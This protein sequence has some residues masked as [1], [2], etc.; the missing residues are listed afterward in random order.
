MAHGD[1]VGGA[2]GGL[3]AGDAGDLEGIAFGIVRQRREGFGGEGDEGGGFGFAAGR[4]FAADV[5]HA[6][7]ARVVKMR[8]L[9]HGEQ[10][11]AFAGAGREGAAGCGT[12]VGWV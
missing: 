6:R 10:S 9:A 11:I 7:V 3:D 4:G 5:D 2:F 8:E 1:E 12:F